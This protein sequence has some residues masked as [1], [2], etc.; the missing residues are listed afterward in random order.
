VAHPL[1]DRSA[2]AVLAIGHTAKERAVAARDGDGWPGGEDT[3]ADLVAVAEQVSQCEGQV[4]AVPEV[5]NCSDSHGESPLR[6]TLHPLQRGCVIL[7]LEMGHW[8]VRGIEYQVLMGVDEARE[9][10]DVAKIN[11]IPGI[12]S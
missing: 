8:V 2:N 10:R 5:A 3:R 4:V 7:G 12:R 1:A 11:D 9:Q 6:G